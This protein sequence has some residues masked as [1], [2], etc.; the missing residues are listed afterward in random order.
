SCGPDPTRDR[1]PRPLPEPLVVE[2]DEF[3][4]GVVD[5]VAPA[6][7]PR[8]ASSEGRPEPH[9][10][11]SSAR[12]RSDWGIVS[13]RAFA[14]LRLM[15]SS[16]FVGCAIGSSAGLAPFKILPT[17]AAEPRNMSDMLGP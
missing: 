1:G 15:T 11:T 12:V 8:N 16:N 17:Y 6:R 14:V 2:L 9:R 7:P 10:I 13:P 5:E 3:H 4:E